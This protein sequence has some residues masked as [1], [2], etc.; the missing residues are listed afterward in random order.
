MVSL[1]PCMLT[2][3]H[4]E[5]PVKWHQRVSSNKLVG[6][7]ASDSVLHEHAQPVEVFLTDGDV[8]KKKT[9]FKR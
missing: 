7:L 1:L 8:D 4:I 5:V 2:H 6:S 3:W 9:L